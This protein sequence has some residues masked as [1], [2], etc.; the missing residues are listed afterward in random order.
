MLVVWQEGTFSKRHRTW[1]TYDIAMIPSGQVICTG[2]VCAGALRQAEHP[3]RRRCPAAR[4]GRPA[5]PRPGRQSQE[6]AC[7]RPTRASV[8]LPSL[9]RRPDWQSL[10]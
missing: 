1:C 3:D 10:I 5:R 4:R 6:Q 8:F 2:T 7:P 9:R